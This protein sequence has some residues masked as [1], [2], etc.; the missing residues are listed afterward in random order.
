MI[1]GMA[2]AL[3]RKELSSR[4]LVSAALGRADET[5]PKLNAFIIVLADRALARASE[6]DDELARGI[7]RGPL[8][9]IPVAL[10]DL[11]H[12]RGIRTTAGSRVF[13]NFVAGYDATVVTRLEE[14]GAVIIGKTG[15]HEFAYGITSNNPHYGPV[16]NPHDPQR[17]PGGSSGGSGAAVAT[18]VVPVA[19]GTDTGG[20]IR[21]P[22]SFC[23]CVGLKATYGRVS[24]HGVLPLGFTLDHIGPLAASVD[25]AAIALAA[26]AGHDPC[27]PTTTK[28]PVE[29]YR[30]GT[31][32]DLRGLRIGRPEKYFFDRLAPEVAGAVAKTFKAASSLGAE[33]VPVTLPDMDEL[34]AVARTI[35]LAEAPAALETHLPSRELFGKDVLALLDQGRLLPATAYIQ[36]QRVRSILLRE[37]RE[38]WTRVDC[39]FTPTTPITAPPIGATKVEIGG[40]EEDVRLASTRLVRAVNLLGVPALSLPCG[41]DGSGLPVGLQIIAPPFREKS[42][43]R[44]GSAIEG[45]LVAAR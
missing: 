40:I 7:D 37:F 25:D 6:L 1:A 29:S 18:A 20:S 33:I 5:N 36:A 35:L 11:I 24:K 41:V 8:H 34:N 19:L 30:P 14:A 44:V 43:L 9:G 42:L 10:K 28:R 39:L 2:A 27:D 15:L 12:M 23:G 21:I 31:V 13:E 4:D 26:L 32:E 38:V 17:I 22:A 3:R 16:R 45:A